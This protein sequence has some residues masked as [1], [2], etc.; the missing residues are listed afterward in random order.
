MSRREMSYCG[1]RL[2]SL[3]LDIADPA[4]LIDKR[5]EQPTHKADYE[6]SEN[7]RPEPKDVKAGNHSGNHL[8]KQGVYNECKKAQSEDID[9]KGDNDQYRP[10]QGIQYAEDQRGK[11]GRREAPHNYAVEQVGSKNN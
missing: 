5:T 11:K 9:R 1:E 7:R 10:E 6:R 3:D 4:P 2:S 8:Q